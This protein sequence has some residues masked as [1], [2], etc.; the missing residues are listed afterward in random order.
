MSQLD[1]VL[2]IEQPVEGTPAG[3]MQSS[4]AMPRLGLTRD[5]MNWAAIA[6]G[7]AVLTLL[8][9][10]ATS[11]VGALLGV[12][13]PAI[14]WYV[15]RNRSEYV[16]EQARQATVF[17]LAGIVGMLGLALV[18]AIAIVLVWV[19]TGLLS[20]VLIGL[21]LIPLALVLTL[22][23]V[24]AVVGLPV[25]MGIYGAYGASEAYNGRPFRYRWIA[26]LVDRY[27]AHA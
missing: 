7:S 8:L 12:A 9:A 4:G 15:Y 23:F 5:E 13:V 25:A 16:A 10:I 20:A 11:G 1:Q 17:Q 27:V 26:D 14:I 6:H 24:V 19:V 22:L 2:E 3:P 21:L 18:G